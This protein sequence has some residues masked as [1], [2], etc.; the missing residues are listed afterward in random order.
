MQS[1]LD[2]KGKKMTAQEAVLR[3]ETRGTCLECS[4]AVRLHRTGR[5]GAPRAHFE[6]L[7]GKKNCSLRH[8]LV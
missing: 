4:E 5:K 8:Y 7:P 3:N 1:A 6:H 2:S